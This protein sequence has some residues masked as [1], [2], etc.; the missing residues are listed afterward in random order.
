MSP[1]PSRRLAG[2][3]SLDPIRR[4]PRP[5]S[6]ASPNQIADRARAT[7]FSGLDD[8]AGRFFEPVAVFFL[9]PLVRVPPRLDAFLAELLRDRAGEDARVAMAPRLA[10]IRAMASEQR[11]ADPTRPEAARSRGPDP[12]REACEA[13]PSPCRAAATR[14]CWG[15]R[16][17]RLD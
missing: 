8:V 2:S 9:L 6:P 13:Y 4:T 5:T 11:R 15:S 3:T 7:G 17:P 10:T 1:A 14:G 12:L 16:L